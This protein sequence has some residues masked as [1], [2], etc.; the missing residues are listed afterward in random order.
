MN[1]ELARRSETQVAFTKDQVDLIKSQIAVGCDTL[2]RP[3][4]DRSRRADD[5]SG[6]T[7]TRGAASPAEPALC[8]LSKRAQ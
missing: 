2:W 4:A 7:L 5:R 3:F 6:S 1:E 8:I